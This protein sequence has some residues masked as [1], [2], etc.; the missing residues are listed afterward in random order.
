M[1]TILKACGKG[2]LYI[3][4]FPVVLVVLSLLATVGIV[5]FIVLGIRAI[6][7]FFKGKSL[8][9]ELPEDI[10]VQKIKSAN[11]VLEGPQEN[12]NQDSNNVYFNSTQI[13][14]FGS[15][16]YETIE[17][18]TKQEETNVESEIKEE[19]PTENNNLNEE[20]KDEF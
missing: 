5:V 10:E 14:S 11:L 7:L 16:E 19:T 3:I 9:N 15:H 12:Q 17:P 1:K 20:N 18:E 13:Y 4:T 2:I 6:V 8:F